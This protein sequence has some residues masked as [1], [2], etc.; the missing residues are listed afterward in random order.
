M[1]L[2]HYQVVSDKRIVETIV[3]NYLL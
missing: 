2:R 1:Q 3:R